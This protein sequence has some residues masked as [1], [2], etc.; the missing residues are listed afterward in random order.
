[1]RTQGG[2]LPEAPAGTEAVELDV[3]QPEHVAAVVER[4]RETC[5]EGLYALINNAGVA[6]PSPVELVDL[7]ELRLLMEVNVVGPLRLI[8]ACLP[9]LRNARG[10]IVNM[11][12]MNGALAL[13]MVGAYSASKFA[14]EALSDVLRVELRPWRVSV[15]V[16]RPGQVRTAIFPKA[17]AALAERSKRIPAEVAPGYTK[18]FARATRFSKRGNER[19]S[20]PAAVAA[21][22][23]K[24]LEARRP[25]A[26]YLMGFDVKGLNL[27]QSLAPTR[28]M[29]RIIAWFMGTRFLVIKP[30]EDQP[31]SP[32]PEPQPH[33]SP[34]RPDTL[35]SS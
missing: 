7:D 33:S 14:L 18:L 12:S 17:L 24:A 19:S 1:M 26:R 3:T 8:Q 31:V 2:E 28:S 35:R 15:S 21:V 6:A 10:R 30:S 11:S 32:R 29:D 5:P 4:L 20:Q 9:L 25:R 16:I 13:P 23:L 27:L 22:V 34:L